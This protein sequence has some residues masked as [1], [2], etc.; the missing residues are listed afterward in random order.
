VAVDRFLSLDSATRLT[1]A[2]WG[3]RVFVR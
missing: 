1:L 3:Y 2:S